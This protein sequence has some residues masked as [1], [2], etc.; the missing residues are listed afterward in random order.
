MSTIGYTINGSILLIHSGYVLPHLNL[1]HTD[2]D[3]K[4]EGTF[5]KINADNDQIEQL[6]RTIVKGPYHNG[7]FVVTSGIGSVE[8]HTRRGTIYQYIY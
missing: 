3:Y 8:V 4:K 1:S 6:A 7:P 2:L 5:I